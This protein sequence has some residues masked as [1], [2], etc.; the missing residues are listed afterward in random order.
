MTGCSKD[1]RDGF[2][3]RDGICRAE[4]FILSC[5]HLIIRGQLDASTDPIIRIVLDDIT[6]I[7]AAGVALRKGNTFQFQGDTDDLLPQDGITQSV[8]A[9]FG[10]T[11]YE[12]SFSCQKVRIADIDLIH[13]E[14]IRRRKEKKAK[15]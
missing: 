4:I 7:I 14:S 13:R 11:V 8:F 10:R 3:D 2:A 6:V 1:D 15:K 5:D 12:D 9:W